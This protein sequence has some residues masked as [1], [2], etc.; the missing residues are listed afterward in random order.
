MEDQPAAGAIWNVI[1]ISGR[2]RATGNMDDAQSVFTVAT[3]QLAAG[4]YILQVISGN[5]V[6][7]SRFQKI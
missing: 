2:I 3:T 1:D 7:T 6:L 5:Q 4:A